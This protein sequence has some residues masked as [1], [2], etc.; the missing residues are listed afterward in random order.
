MF[1]TGSSAACSC[2]G[3]AIPRYSRGGTRRALGRA[4]SVIQRSR[5]RQNQANPL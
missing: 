1:R 2:F 5:Y 3:A 4:S